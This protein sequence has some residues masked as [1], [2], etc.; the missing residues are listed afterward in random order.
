MPLLSDRIHIAQLS[1]TLTHTPTHIYS[2]IHQIQYYMR[3]NDGDGRIDEYVCVALNIIYTHLYSYCADRACVSTSEVYN[4]CCFC[5]LEISFSNNNIECVVDTGPI[6]M[7]C[8]VLHGSIHFDYAC[9]CECCTGPIC[10]SRPRPTK[11]I[12]NCIGLCVCGNS[13]ALK[14]EM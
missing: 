7:L 13:C 1:T 10:C 2:T 12:G 9:V 8:S 4:L 14:L 3:S 11:Q 6:Q 5:S